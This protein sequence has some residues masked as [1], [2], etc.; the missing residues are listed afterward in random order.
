MNCAE[1]L[2]AFKKPEDD[3]VVVLLV[4]PD[5]SSIAFSFNWSFHRSILHLRFE[6]KGAAIAAP[7][8][9]SFKLA[10]GEIAQDTASLPSCV[11]KPRS[12]RPFS[13]SS[14]IGNLLIAVPL[15]IENH[16]LCMRLA[17]SGK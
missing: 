12:H 16:R 3:H 10:L 14:Q 17:E 5:D 4:S 8:F 1:S 13:H 2:S 7:V 11:M 6:N 15:Q 9:V